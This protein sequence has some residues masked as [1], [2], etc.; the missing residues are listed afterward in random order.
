MAPSKSQCFI[1]TLLATASQYS[2]ALLSADPSFT[3]L[4]NTH[5]HTLSRSKSAQLS[6]SP[7]QKYGHRHNIRPTLLPL[8][9]S[10]KTTG[11]ENNDPSALTPTRKKTKPKK[12]NKYANF[13]KAANLSM[14][15]LE[16]L[17]NES[18]TKLR[19]LHE[20]TATSQSSPKKRQR[21]KKILSKMTS[22]EAVDELLASVD[23]NDDEVEEEEAV[24][25]EKRV[26]NKRQFPDTTTI[27]PYDPTT[28]GYVELGTIIGAH[29]VHGFL[30]L[31]STT[32]FSE[33]RLCEPGIRHIKPPNRRSPREVQLA[34]GR[35]L[36]PDSATTGSDA[37]P[38]Y[39][40]RLEH[41]QDRE[42]ALKLR[43]C[44]L[45]SLE[46]EKVDDLLDEGEYIVSD[47]IGLNVFLDEQ[48]Y[49]DAKKDLFVGN[50]RG[51][52]MGSEICAIPGLG[53]D[54]LEVLLPKR[55]EL[56]RGEEMVLIPFVPQIVSRVDLDLRM[57][58]VKPPAGLLDLSYVREEKVKIKGFL[59]AARY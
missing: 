44:V 56:Q 17:L 10:R 26:R 38:I 19:D 47:L 43:G 36:R 31:S 4:Q 20:E 3:F 53:Q 5:H 2:H 40:I 51:V 50:I 1:S 42:S 27:D 52:V 34:E 54:L 46:D 41:I 29:G 39:L 58:F 6:P 9:T 30:K 35:P 15:P 22:L 55:K 11:E 16:A 24:E 28:Y 33:K 32:D 14:D 13:S 48:V 18:R 12:K 21:N 57:V 37:N 23:A 59:P 49:G 45:Y 25:F 8:Y 7:F